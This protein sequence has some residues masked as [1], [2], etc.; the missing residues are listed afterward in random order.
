MSSELPDE[1]QNTLSNL[2]TSLTNLEEILKPILEVP[3]D[4]LT[5][6][7]DPLEKAKLNLMMA[8][9]AASLFYMYLKTQVRLYVCATT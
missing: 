6:R 3:W 7:L 4:S 8:Y 9:S 2:D 1:I 5:G